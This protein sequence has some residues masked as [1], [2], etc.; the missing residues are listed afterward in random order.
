MKLESILEFRQT[1]DLYTY[2]VNL[3]AYREVQERARQLVGCKSENPNWRIPVD[4]IDLICGDIP[5]N[6]IDLPPVFPVQ[7]VYHPKFKPFQ[8]ETVSW[9]LNK[10]AG[11]IH[12]EMGLG[13]TP[14]S[15]ITTVYRYEEGE[16]ILIVCP[17]SVKSQWAKQLNNWW[18]AHPSVGVHKKKTISEN[19]TIVNY[20]NLVKYKNHRFDHIIFDEIHYLQNEDSQRSIAARQLLKT[21]PYAYKIGLTAT[22]ITT[23]LRGLWNQVDL[24]WSGLFGTIIWQFLS[25]YCVLEDDGYGQDVKGL[26][27]EKISELNHRLSHYFFRKTKAEV[28]YLLPKIKTEKI[29]IKAERVIG[30]KQLVER[31]NVMHAHKEQISKHLQSRYEEKINAVCRRVEDSL[32][33]TD[34]HVVVLTYNRDLACRLADLLAHSTRHVSL[35]MGSGEGGG[36]SA[37]RR[38]T[39]IE[40]AW[41]SKKGVVVATMSSIGVGLDNLVKATRVFFAQLFYSQGL[42]EQVTG[43]FNRFSSEHDVVIEFLIS[44]G[45]I[46]EQIAYVLE[47]RINEQ[48][49][50]IQ[51]G[52]TVKSVHNALVT[53][54]YTD[55]EFWADVQAAASNVVE[56]NYL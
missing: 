6:R 56:D 55:E 30:A 38:E 33:S 42:V 1:P 18:P 20:E 53:S 43:R 40:E 34:D 25:I 45:T 31:Y 35:V 21:N 16:R 15:I 32:S 24:F 48:S 11:M 10:R 46:D 12:Y 4:C 49:K 3:S 9:L 27:P 22:P 14:V 37:E 8:N 47:K 29:T 13:K 5:Y 41:A 51:Q 26:K 28:A 54:T 39:A 23:D 2:L 44:A 17:A 50:I 19:I 7:D 52:E 36:G